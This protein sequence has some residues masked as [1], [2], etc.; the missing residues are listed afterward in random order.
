MEII[1]LAVAIFPWRS[2]DFA[3]SP[4]ILA[5]KPPKK[6]TLAASRQVNHVS[7]ALYSWRILL[8]GQ[9]PR[10][11][12]LAVLVYSLAVFGCQGNSSLV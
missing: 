4:S 3:V 8:S 5:A 1:S 12:F 7:L 2:E 6:I 9:P 10:M 11:I